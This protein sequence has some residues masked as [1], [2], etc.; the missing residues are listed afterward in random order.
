M[1]KG[2]PGKN[3]LD[4][5]P[6]A[7]G[8]DGLNGAPGLQGPMGPAGPPGYTGNK[9]FNFINL[10]IDR[11]NTIPLKKSRSY[12]CTWKGWLQRPPR[13]SWTCWTSR[14]ILYFVVNFKL[15]ND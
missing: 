14:Q 2:A 15:R 11:R 9:K 5:V 10:C 6:G 13:P 12:W 7:R 4:G 8:K 1:I 3:G